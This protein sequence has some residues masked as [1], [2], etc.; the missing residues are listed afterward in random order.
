MENVI[1]GSQKGKDSVRHKRIESVQKLVSRK[2][3]MDIKE[4]VIVY[5]RKQTSIIY[6]LIYLFTQP[7]LAEHQLSTS[8]VLGTVEIVQAKT[9]IDWLNDCGKVTQRDSGSGHKEIMLQWKGQVS[10]E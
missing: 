6:L 1:Q 10:I 7:V 3:D 8:P 5:K 9:L 4:T 2:G